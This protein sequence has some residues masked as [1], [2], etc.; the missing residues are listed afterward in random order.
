[1][2]LPDLKSRFRN[3]VGA[4]ALGTML[5]VAPFNSAVA[6]ESPANGASVA[7]NN[8]AAATTGANSTTSSTTAP[9]PNA[10]DLARSAQR[11]SK[12]NDAVGMFVTIAPGSGFTH[13]SLGD[14]L[15]RKFAREGIEAKYTFNYAESGD[16]VIDFFVR[17][18]P[19]TG[20]G[21]GKL[22]EGYTLVAKTIRALRSD[23]VANA[24][25]AYNND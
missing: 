12:D 9:A 25:F 6:E 10:W 5:I 14:A 17:G 19:Y 18:V 15:V 20:Y 16:S 3:T 21:L 22:E 7:N 4:A 23:R 24:D 1:M 2:S 8:V 13:Q 11:Y